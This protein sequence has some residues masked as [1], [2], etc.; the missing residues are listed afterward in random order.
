MV[1][2]LRQHSS[3]TE[4][5]WRFVALS[6][7]IRHH[8]SLLLQNFWESWRLFSGTIKV[9]FMLLRF[10]SKHLAYWI[11]PQAPSF[12]WSYN[13]AW[14]FRYLEYLPWTLLK[15]ESFLKRVF[16][17]DAIEEHFWVPQRAFQW[18]VEKSVRRKK[19]L[20]SYCSF[21][22]TTLSVEFMEMSLIS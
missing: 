5:S 7:E 10:L 15:N 6:N 12:Q 16:H 8:V 9:I 14:I 20:Q 21:S 13:S 18:I 22:D 17:S 3:I 19:N 4:S 2:G 11:Q 1:A